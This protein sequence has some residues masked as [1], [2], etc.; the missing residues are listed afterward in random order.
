MK[1]VILGANGGTGAHVIAVALSRGMTVT[2]VVRSPEKAPTLR[3]ERLTIAMG[4]PCAPGFLR[5]VL[6]GH[7][8]VISTLGGK[9]PTKAATSVFYRSAR[10]LVDAAWDT[11][12][13]RVLVTST[14]LLF[15]DQPLFGRLLKRVVPNVVSSA[16]RM[17]DIL[18][19]SGLNWTTARP[20]FLNNSAE[21]TYRAQKG[22]MPADGS[23]V[24][25]RAL[26]Q[27]LVDASGDPETHRAAFGIARAVGRS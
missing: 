13:N 20:G 7:D 14:A 22:A 27:F 9:R 6:P 17:E 3:H 11:G 5:S 25:R 18:A 4:D 15:D 1:L 10:A 21:V 23:S 8:A 12:V 26:A 24:S 2:A 16:A 19:A